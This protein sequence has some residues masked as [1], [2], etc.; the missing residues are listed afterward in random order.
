MLIY[1]FKKEIDTN[2]IFNTVSENRKAI[3]VSRKIYAQK[4]RQLILYKEFHG[5]KYDYY[6]GKYFEDYSYLIRMLKEEITEISN[7]I[8][9]LKKVIKDDRN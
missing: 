6:K 3:N 8:W 4:Y 1:S 2:K 5:I 7:Y 9:K